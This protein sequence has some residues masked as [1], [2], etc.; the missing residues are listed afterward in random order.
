MRNT[1]LLLLIFFP[2]LIFSK[3]YIES[4][5]SSAV[6]NSLL[7]YLLP[8]DSKLSE[9]ASRF[10]IN[11]TDL[12]GANAFNA[13]KPF[14]GNEI[15]PQKTLLRIPIQ[16]PCVDGIRRS[17]STSYIVRAIDTVSSIAAGFG[18][19]VSA[20][21]IQTT[22]GI[23][24]TDGL[25]IGQSLV[26]PL[27]CTCLHNR[28]NGVTVIYMSYVVRERESLRSI[29]EMYGTTVTDLV[30]VN[31]LGTPFVYPG[32]ILTVPLPACSSAY[33]KLRHS[34]KLLVPNG[35]YALTAL[36]CVECTCGPKDL[37]LRCFPAP[38]AVS[39]SNFMCEQTNLSIGDIFVQPTSTGCNVI[40][41]LYRGHKGHKILSSLSN[42]SQV[43]CSG[44]TR[45]SA[46]PTSS[47]PTVNQSIFPSEPS[48]PTPNPNPDD[49][50]LLATVAYGPTSR[51]DSST[52]VAG[53]ASKHGL[54]F[55]L[56]QVELI[57]LACL[58]LI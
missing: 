56:L 43:L 14:S 38:L 2:P 24:E 54:F 7:S 23:S 32:D 51:P 30:T 37:I 13:A 17:L 4:C 42:T 52:S 12:L 40:T 27:P 28:D 53:D 25:E 20:E 31:G 16:C 47:F 26:I 44:T 45:R 58:E 36:G 33:L 57:L 1:V 15:L 11:V 3:S 49:V 19:L 22:N 41:C 21:Q 55:R 5:H 18:G 10:Q 34:E 6:C 46:L 8:Y 50:P 35:S 39:C 29:G 9:I 48:S